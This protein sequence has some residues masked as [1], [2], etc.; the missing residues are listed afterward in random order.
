MDSDNTFSTI[1]EK[2]NDSMNTL[3]TE[4]AEREFVKMMNQSEKRG[5][6]YK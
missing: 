3:I 6:F 4:E 2:Q 5:E 1:V